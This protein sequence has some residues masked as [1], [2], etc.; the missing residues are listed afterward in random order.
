MGDGEMEEGEKVEGEV[1]RSVVRV[2]EG[3]MILSLD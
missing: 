2:E 3:F 1:G